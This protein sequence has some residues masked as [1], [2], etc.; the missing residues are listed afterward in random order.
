MP[1]PTA[2]APPVALPGTELWRR[3]V[4]LLARLGRRRTAPARLSRP[5]RIRALVEVLDEAV[6]V[7]QPADAAV[8]AC[9]ESGLVT[10]RTAQECGRAGTKFHRLRARLRELPL[11]EADLVETQAYAGRLPAYDQWLVRQSPSLAFT[12]HS[13]A[14]TEAARLHI[15]GLG[16]PADNLRRLRDA[17]KPGS[18]PCE[19]H[20]DE[21]RRTTWSS[22]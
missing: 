2:L 4:R 19:D 16:R 22:L 3:I 8:A 7:Q 21:A 11:A 13:D 14:R 12:V 20:T 17:L 6:C 10:G 1:A 15:N 9:G 5:A 18:R